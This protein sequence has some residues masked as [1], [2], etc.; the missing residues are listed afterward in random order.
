MGNP[1][2]SDPELR[3]FKTQIEITG[4]GNEGQEKL[5]LAKVAVVGSGG[6]GASV[7]Q[8]LASFGL[9][10]L[11]IIDDEIVNESNIQR[12]TLYGGT[13]LGK[14]KTIISRQHLQDLFPLNHYEIINLKLSSENAEKILGQ[15]SLIVDA[16]N[17]SHSSLIINDACVK[18]N[19]PW[20]FGHVSG[21]V[22]RVS[23][24][25]YMGGP[26]YRCLGSKDSSELQ[27]L[28]SISSTYA[29]AGVFISNEVFKIT[30]NQPNT[31]SGKL[32]TFDSFTYM[33][34]IQQVIRVESNFRLSG[35]LV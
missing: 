5:K 25:N 34:E 21:N 24:F 23:V 31:L 27:N 19:K 2:L 6:T 8:N 22:V 1:V 12:Q 35:S 18:M 7:L 14:L 4:I 28:G 11:G 32:L 15:F 26:S 20:V 29:L 9:G 16:T 30:T 3:R 33:N 13:D 17:D 10:Y